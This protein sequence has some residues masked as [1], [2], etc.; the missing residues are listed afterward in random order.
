MTY[1]VKHELEPTATP[2]DKL[3]QELKTAIDKLT[4][5]ELQAWLAEMKAAEKQAYINSINALIEG[6]TVEALDEI[7]AYIARIED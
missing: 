3:R 5:P 2:E 7:E 1:R 4:M 6:M